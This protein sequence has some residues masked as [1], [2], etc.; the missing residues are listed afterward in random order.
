MNLEIA[1]DEKNLKIYTLTFSG[2]LPRFEQEANAFETLEKK[3]PGFFGVAVTK[4]TDSNVVELLIRN[5]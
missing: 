2:E 5:Y 1:K 4:T 3:H